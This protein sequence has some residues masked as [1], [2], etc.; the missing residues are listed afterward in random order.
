MSIERRQPIPLNVTESSIPGRFRP[1]SFS[2]SA[3]RLFVLSVIFFLF[4]LA[5]FPPA[6]Y[7]ATAG[8]LSKIKRERQDVERTLINLKKELDVYQK[9]LNATKRQETT[10][11]RRLKTLQNKITALGELIRENQRYLAVLDRDI[12]RLEG[13]FK[14]NRQV[15]GRVSSAFGRTAVAVYKYGVDREMENVFAARSVN[16]A[17]VKAQYIGFFAQAVHGHVDTL[18]QVARELEHNRAELEKSYR[19]KAEA[20]KDQERQL[21]NY[22]ASKS[23]KETALVKLKEEKAAYTEKV[24]AARRKRRQLQGRIEALI[25]AE[26]RAIEA[27]QARRL[28][29]QPAPQ[30]APAPG[31]A[32][33]PAAGRRVPPPPD[34]PELRKVSADFDRAFGQLPWPVANGRVSQRF[35]S[36][37]DAELKIVT[38]NNGI[39]I[40]VPAGTPVKAVSGGKVAQIAFMP[41]FGNIVIIRHPNSYLT[42]YANLGDLRVTKNDL[43]ASQQLI[44]LSGRNPDGG[45]VVHFEIWKAGVK[46]N[47]EKWLR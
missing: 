1:F 37:T 9:K 26:Q 42:V 43:I 44:G 2:H 10:S 24:L 46:Q 8:E 41:T 19:A 11:L 35:G 3:A 4:H 17:I 14:E 6:A 40:A 36:V 29:A 5:A 27:E 30:K 39:D 20:V 28:A 22:A 23:E 18:Q 16:D 7:G 32:P 47:P 31:K 25:R 34:S 45:S 38:T 21:K 33:A 13:Q 15:Y 12:D